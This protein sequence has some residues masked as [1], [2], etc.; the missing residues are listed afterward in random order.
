MEN[1]EAMEAKKKAA[2]KLTMRIITI[3]AVIVIGYVVYAMITK[4]VNMV[5]FEILLG[6]FVIAYLL[7]T[8]VME[9]WKTGLLAELTP[10]R[11]NAYIKLLLLDV[12]GGAALLYWVVGMNSESGNNNILIPVV[13]YIVAMQMKKKVRPEFEVLDEELEQQDEES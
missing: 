12:A 1:K 8:D 13:I 5:I 9:P 4:N 2:Q 7:L 3:L 10:R 6:S 11:K